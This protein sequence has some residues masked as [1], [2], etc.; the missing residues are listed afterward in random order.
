[1]RE[2]RGTVGGNGM[3]NANDNDNDNDEGSYGAGHAPLLSTDRHYAS[4]FS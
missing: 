4:I 2:F 1:M 3:G